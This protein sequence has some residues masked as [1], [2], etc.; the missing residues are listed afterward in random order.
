MYSSQENI[1]LALL[2]NSSHLFWSLHQFLVRFRLVEGSLSASA[3]SRLCAL[4]FNTHPYK[5]QTTCA[6]DGLQ[7]VQQMYQGRYIVS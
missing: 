1:T 7:H 4:S 3:I 5:K 2:D 6:E